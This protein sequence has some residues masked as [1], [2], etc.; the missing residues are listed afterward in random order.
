ME[1]SEQEIQGH[2][3]SL[4]SRSADWASNEEARSPGA[5]SFVERKVSLLAR[6][7]SANVRKRKRGGE[8][9]FE[10]TCCAELSPRK[11]P[12]AWDDC[13]RCRWT[14]LGK[15]AREGNKLKL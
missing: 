8:V 4:S 14:S 2:L 10:M 3:V 12:A 11:S 15:E 6:R 9:K 7:L 13:R 1:E 5:S